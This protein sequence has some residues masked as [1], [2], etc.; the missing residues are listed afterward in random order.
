M[1]RFLRR[2]RY[3][4]KQRDFEDALHEELEFHRAMKQQRFEADGLAPGDATYAS[5]REMG[6]VAMACERPCGVDLAMA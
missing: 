3:W 5:R 1:A 4:F 6:N 2:I